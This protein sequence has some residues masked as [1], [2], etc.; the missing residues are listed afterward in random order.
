[1]VG[2]ATDVAKETADLILL[3]N[4]FR[5]VVAAVEEGRTIFPKHP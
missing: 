5:T 1:V 4:N 3:D 2:A